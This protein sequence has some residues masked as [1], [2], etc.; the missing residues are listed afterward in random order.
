[1][2]QIIHLESV[3]FTCTSK[4][5]WIQPGSTHI[6]QIGIRSSACGPVKP[7]SLAHESS[8]TTTLWWL[9]GMVLTYHEY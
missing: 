9:I 8:L 7:A 1:M 4:L 6:S 2:Q 3:L 5:I